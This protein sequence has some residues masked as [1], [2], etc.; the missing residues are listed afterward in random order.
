MAVK[1]LGRMRAPFP[2]PDMFYSNSTSECSLESQCTGVGK[3]SA[4]FMQKHAMDPKALFNL[5]KRVSTLDPSLCFG[6][7][8]D[9]YIAQNGL[10]NI[11]KILVIKTVI[12]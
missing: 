10:W 4:K 3:H 6:Y 7:N 12:D 1:D 2:I 9:I 11:L 8:P 5:E